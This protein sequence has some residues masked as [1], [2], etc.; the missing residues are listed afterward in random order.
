MNLTVKFTCLKRENNKALKLTE[1]I[2]K[3]SQ[4]YGEIK[5]NESKIKNKQLISYTITVLYENISCQG[6]PL[7]IW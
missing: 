7:R 4:N 6:I 3:I 1:F 5:T 2:M